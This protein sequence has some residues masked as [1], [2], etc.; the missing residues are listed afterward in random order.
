VLLSAAIAVGACGDVRRDTVVLRTASGPEREVS[1]FIGN[2]VTVELSAAAMEA[3]SRNLGEVVVR[4]DRQER[5]FVFLGA[6]LA[7]GVTGAEVLAVPLPA[8]DDEVVTLPLAPEDAARAA[9]VRVYDTGLCSRFEPYD[10][11]AA[12]LG[13]ALVRALGTVHFERSGPS[14]P[15]ETEEVLVFEGLSLVSAAVTPTLASSPEVPAGDADTLRL[16]AVVR[17]A[18]ITHPV[19]MPPGLE[20]WESCTDVEVLIDV[21]LRLR[22]VPGQLLAEPCPRGQESL[23][24]ADAGSDEPLHD[25]EPTL[26]ADEVIDMRHVDGGAGRCGPGLSLADVPP[27]GV[28]RVRDLA[29]YGLRAFFP[30]EVRWALRRAVLVPY[31]DLGLAPQPCGEPFGCLDL[32]GAPARRGETGVRPQCVRAAGGGEGTCAVQLEPTRLSVRPDGLEIVLYEDVRSE[33]YARL[34]EGR[35]AALAAPVAA[36][37]DVGRGLPP[38]VEHA[39]PGRSARRFSMPSR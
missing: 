37:C 11:V 19:D 9:S 4:A 31:A 15:D 17:A 29:L 22:S 30:R 26:P 2:D 3:T 14:G 34:F 38:G 39:S 36:L 1:R 32:I 18:R 21:G 33:Q 10:A 27:A 8:R 20:P 6:D 13:E 35:R 24:D 28:R 16:R 5:V 23:C 25:F 7:T 12:R